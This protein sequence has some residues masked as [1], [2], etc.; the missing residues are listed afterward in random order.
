MFLKVKASRTLIYKTFTLS[1]SIYQMRES[2][3]Q[4]IVLRLRP[5]LVR[6]EG[7]QWLQAFMETTT[8]LFIMPFV[9]VA[10]VWLVVATDWGEISGRLLPFL[11]LFVM[12][13]LAQQQPFTLDL[14][15]G[16]GQFVSIIG[17][18]SSLILWAAMLVF[19]ANVLWVP[20][21]VTAGGNLWQGRQRRRLNQDPFWEP[22]SLFVQEVGG[23]IFAGLV[24][25][26]VYESLG[27]TIPLTNQQ[28]EKWLP[29]VYAILIYVLLQEIILLPIVIQLN[30]LTATPNTFG[31]IGIFLLSVGWP[32]LFMAPFAILAPLLYIQGGSGLFFFFLTGV[33]LVN[34]LAHH[35][36]RA[37]ER[38]RQRARELMQLEAL[39][40]A[41]IQ[42]PAD[43][44]T[45]QELLASHV[46]SMFPQ[47]IVEV[48][49]FP[50][51][52]NKA[53]KGARVDLV[54]PTFH[55]YYPV[56]HAPVTESVWQHLKQTPGSH[57]I[58]HR[59]IL[60]GAKAVYGDAVVV[61]IM[62]TSPKLA[63][64]TQ[65][66]MTSV[67]AGGIY[68]LRNKTLGKTIDSLPTAQS[69]AS[70]IGSALYRAQ[71]YAQ[72]LAEQM[73]R[74]RRLRATVIKLRIEIDAHQKQK[75]IES[76]VET[77]YFK[78]LEVNAEQ[79]RHNIKGTRNV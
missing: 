14:K 73:E 75:Q 28:P 66:S 23:V 17:S 9:V 33:L 50:L 72:S 24:A 46:S 59:V 34:L 38:W 37:N 63:D 42:A 77:D 4:A 62:T 48:R 35:L 1:P 51:N 8:V 13:L 67:C 10:L 55:I 71:E 49:L 15:L 52:D 16:A 21:L 7:A 79:L 44:S 70:Q 3:L 56:T 41:I 68:L 43:A 64:S 61:K 31:N 26:T 12:L 78:H 60:P 47:D 27:G 2:K 11:S 36:S 18:L 19:G 39:G 53:D 65:K 76:V 5:E 40:Q 25:L 58:E 29:V 57:F 54:C 74:E 69:L 6:L 22:L 45:L 30:R 32:T 20:L